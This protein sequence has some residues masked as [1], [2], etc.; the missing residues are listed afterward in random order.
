M[1]RTALILCSLLALA[2]TSLGFR[3]ATNALHFDQNGPAVRFSA[4]D[5]VLTLH[6]GDRLGSYQI[7]LAP[8]AEQHTRVRVVGIEG[9]EHA[10]FRTPP[11]YDPTAIGHERVIIAAYSTDADLPGGT[12]RVARV[13]YEITGRGE[14]PTLAQL[15]EIRA[16]LATD[17]TGEAIDASSRLT[18]SQGNQP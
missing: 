15:I 3:A 2:V 7:E 14:L 13:H 6:E 11:F 16:A 5:V 8:L 18:P 9:G 10:A 17:R 4:I 1:L 12:T